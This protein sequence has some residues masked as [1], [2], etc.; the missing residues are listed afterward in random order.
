MWR[1]QRTPKEDGNE[2][3]LSGVRLDG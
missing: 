2:V 1:D 3:P